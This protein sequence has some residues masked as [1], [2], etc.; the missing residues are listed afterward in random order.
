MNYFCVLVKFGIEFGNLLSLDFHVL[1]CVK[2]CLDWSVEAQWGKRWSVAEY[3][4]VSKNW[5]AQ[6]YK[7]HYL[8][9]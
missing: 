8:Y 6:A 5:S 1:P 9:I 3:R 7:I 4:P 2:K